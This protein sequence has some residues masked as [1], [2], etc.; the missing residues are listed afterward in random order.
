MLGLR[1]REDV[2]V[3]DT[4]DFVDGMEERWDVG[5]VAE[6]LRETF[7]PRS[8]GGSGSAE[9][10]APAA[11]IDV[12]ITFDRGGVSSHPNHI[13]LY[14]GAKEWLGGL[15]KGR[16]G[17]RCPVELHTLTSVSIARKY[18]GFLDAPATMLLGFLSGIRAS[19]KESKSEGRRQS[20]FVSDVG[21]WRQGQ[22]AMTRAHQSQMRWFRWGWISFGRYMIVNDL[23]REAL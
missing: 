21:Q 11:T 4:V 8:G 20:L 19:R 5:T 13:A 18:V 23:K 12:L 6:V 3:L 22:K 2:L 10:D 17:W 14:Y 16:Q 7:S 15:M 1:R 9:T